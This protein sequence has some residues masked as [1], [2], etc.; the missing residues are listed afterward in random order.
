MS[1]SFD[2]EA[3]VFSADPAVV[4][5]ANSSL[6]QAGINPVVLGESD[7][8]AECLYRK[9]IDAIVV[10]LNL[11][12]AISALR[13][14]PNTPSNSSVPRFAVTSSTFRNFDWLAHFIFEAPVDQA[15]LTRALRMAYPTML[16]ERHRYQRHELRVPVSITLASG[17]QH[18][19]V[20]VNISEGGLALQC[21]INL[22]N[23]DQ[24]DIELPLRKDL[25]IR[26]HAEVVWS[27]SKTLTGLKFLF[28]KPA[29][30]QV[31]RAWLADQY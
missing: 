13:D 23:H 14:L 2:L 22:K 7:A 17:E 3:I 25:T 30:R 24:L 29:A 26:C 6:S 20:C 10:D 21:E 11:D 18:T 1:S 19:A 5:V 15:L 4:Q 31:L 16:R 27:N 9:K 12:S 28:I 8:A